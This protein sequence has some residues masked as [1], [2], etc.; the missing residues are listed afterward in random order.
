VS[1]DA[2]R[3]QQVVWNL[4]SNA[5]KFTR[6][7]GLVEVRFQR[8]NS[9]VEIVVSDSGEGIK[10]DFLPHVFERFRQADGSTTRAH[11]GLGLGLAIVRHLVELHGGRV[12]AASAGEGKGA[13]FTVKLPLLMADEQALTDFQPKP[14]PGLEALRVDPSSLLV[15]W[16]IL[17]VDDEADARELISTM[18]QSCGAIVKTA[19]STG[20]ALELITKW[21][22]RVLIADIGMEGEDGYALIRKLRSLSENDGGTIPA[23]ALTAY[24]R[25]EDKHRALSSGFQLHLAKPVDRN[26]LAMAVSGL[27]GKSATN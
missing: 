14:V 1:G 5:V 9:H 16:R 6:S 11:G 12:S 7:G 10:A 26:Q 8:N 2:D 21:K 25:I 27:T 4:L 19:A 15:A 17:V 13:T 24:A 23:V 3:L 18:L 20:E 22:P